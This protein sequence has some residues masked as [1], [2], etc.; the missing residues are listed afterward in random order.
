MNYTYDSSSF[1][2]FLVSFRNKSLPIVRDST[3]FLFPCDIIKT[4][5]YQQIRNK[6]AFLASQENLIGDG[7]DVDLKDR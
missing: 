4:A 1:L 2:Q 3:V 7:R 6:Y 5:N